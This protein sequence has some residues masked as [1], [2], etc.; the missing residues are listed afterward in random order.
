MRWKQPQM[1]YNILHCIIVYS[2]NIKP[3]CRSTLWKT[4]YTLSASIGNKRVH[5]LISCIWLSWARCEHLHKSRSFDWSGTCRCA[6]TK[7]HRGKIPINLRKV[8]RPFLNNLKSIILQGE[9]LFT[10]GEHSKLLPV[11]LRV[12]V[13]SKFSPSSKKQ[14]Q[15]QCYMPDCTGLSEHVKCQLKKDWTSMACLAG[16]SSRKC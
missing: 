13:P 5:K 3:K 9:R 1:D 6:L 11:L 2:T 16:F 15:S 14:Q 12:D 4:R 7:C 10:S 8:I